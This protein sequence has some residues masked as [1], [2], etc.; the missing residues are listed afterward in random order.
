MLARSEHRASRWDPIDLAALAA[1]TVERC[2]STAAA[3]GIEFR[4]ELGRCPVAGDAA[5]LD[6]LVGNLVDNATRHNRSPGGWVEVTTTVADGHALLHVMN[7]GP[8]V[9]ADEIPA[10][11][12]PFTRQSGA[13]LGDAKGFGLGLSIVA[14]VVSAHGGRVEARPGPEGGLLVTVQL[15]VGPQVEPI[16]PWEADD[17]APLSAA[18][19]PVRPR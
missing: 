17:A 13:R 4:L 6:R 3:A 7:S 16:A 14:A 10:L 8:P 18:G 1:H 12:E 5:L 11:F 2:R 15:P 9:D 19:A